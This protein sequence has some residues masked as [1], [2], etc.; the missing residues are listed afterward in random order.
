LKKSQTNSENRS[1]V[2]NVD[3][4]HDDNATDVEVHT[5]EF[6]EDDDGNSAS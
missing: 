5:A 2:A 1:L 6:D 3:D 4:G